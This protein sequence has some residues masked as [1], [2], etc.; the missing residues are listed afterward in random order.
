[1]IYRNSKI[2]S[3]WVKKCLTL[4]VLAVIA[5]LFYSSHLL[6]TVVVAISSLFGAYELWRIVTNPVKVRFSEVLS[7]S[8]LLG[9]VVGTGIYLVYLQTTKATDLQ[10]WQ[11]Y[12]VYYDQESLGFALAAVLLSSALLYAASAWETPK[13]ALAGIVELSTTKAERLVWLGILLILLGLYTGQVGYM[14]MQIADSGRVTALGALATLMAPSLVP[15]TVALAIGERPLVKR[16]LLWGALALLIGVTFLLGRRFLIYVL[17]LSAMVLFARP[18][19]PSMRRLATIALL[20]AMAVTVLY[21][22]FK[23]FM[24]LRLAVWELGPDAGLLAQVGAALSMLGGDQSQEVGAR[25]T[26]NAGTRT[27]ILSYFAGL[28][29]NSNGNMPTLGK[30]VLYSIRMAVPSLFLPDKT[31]SL[32]S[33]PEEFMHPLYGIPVFDGPNSI[34]VAGY[35]DF[36]L[37]GAAL[38]PLAF[39]MLYAGFYSTICRMTRLQPIR[40]FVFFALSFQLLYIEQSLAGVFAALRNLVILIMIF[41]IMMSA[42]LMSFSTPLRGRNRRSASFAAPTHVTLSVFR[43]DK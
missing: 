15:F 40:L 43:K 8:I 42:P 24:A 29:Q 35:D 27:F 20:G 11:H 34:V 14:G 10:Y 32:P 30:E 25:L 38:Y 31:T 9:Y 4:C 39:A 26:E 5:A 21:W 18:N 1:M 23:F 16:L 17:V 12:G 2:T 7:I 41:W 3:S 28:M 33:S 13:R 37:I 22:G 6:F 19:R 36:G